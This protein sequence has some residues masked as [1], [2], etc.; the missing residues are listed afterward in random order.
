MEIPGPIMYKP[1]PIG[2]GGF[3]NTFTAAQIIT[4]VDKRRV[5]PGYD[6]EVGSTIELEADIEFSTTGAPTLAVGFF[7]GTAAVLL[8]LGQLVAT[9]SGA[10]AWSTNIK[11][12]GKVLSIGTGGANIG[13]IHGVMTELR[14]SSLTALGTPVPAPITAAAR[15]V[16]IDT[17]VNKELG[18]AAQW[19]T[20]SASN[21][22]R[23]LNFTAQR[24][25]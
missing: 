17:T 11:Y 23:V 13:Q 5:I 9:G 24:T 2:L 12:R 25:S 1:E 8:A 18:V 20:S 16:S 14:E 10:A 6:L 21:T 7:Y 19:G 22:L 3:Y 15:T 4:D